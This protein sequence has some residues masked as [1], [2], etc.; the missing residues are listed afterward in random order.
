LVDRYLR[1]VL[2]LRVHRDGRPIRIVYTPLH[3]VGA[4]IALRVLAEAGY[5]DVIPV[6]EQVEPDG[7]FPTVRFPNPEEPGAMDLALS[8]AER[9]QADL[10]LAN[11]PDAD[12]IA[13]AVPTPR[14]SGRGWRRLT[15]NEVG[16]LI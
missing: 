4:E 16:T 15:G 7:A 1:E 12:R 6:P 5:A 8:L 10:V 13:V 11:D 9:V 2:A 3:G 14:S